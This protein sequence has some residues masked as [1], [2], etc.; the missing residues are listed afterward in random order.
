M[1]AGGQSLG[2]MLNLRLA[3]PALLVDI[4]RIPELAAVS[5]DGDAVTIGATR[6]ACRHRGRP[7]PRSDRRLSARASRAASPIARCARAARSAAASPMPIRPPTGSPCLAA[8]GAEV[9]IAGAGRQRAACRSP[10]FVRGA[11]ETELGRGRAAGRRA[12]SR[13]SRAR[14]AS[15][16][17]R[18]AARPASSPTPS[19]SSSTIRTAAL[20]G[21]SRAR[22]PARPIVHRSAEAAI[23][24]DRPMRPTCERRLVGWRASPATPTSC[25]CT[26]SPLQR[27]V[28]R[29]AGRMTR[30]A[31]TV[32][33][34]AG[35]RPRSR[36]ART[37]PTSCA[38]TCCSPARISAA[39]TASAAPARSRSTARSPARAS[40]TR[41]PATA[42]S[43]RT[44]E[45]FDDDA[46]MAPP[47]PGLHARRTRCSAATARPAC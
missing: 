30:I 8:L 1:L 45:G 12:H 26:P 13:S 42:P 34:K 35:R 32:N 38:S 47:A 25:S 33:G 41:S 7:R 22:R 21:W 27:A 5:E 23:A 24:R 15:A 11:M 20:L 16:S 40:P 6:H 43:V 10:A 44:I 36:R 14:R 29:G 9:V 3:Q 17:T 4:T 2:P 46:L 28:A 18:S 31:L 19:A 39:S 37:S